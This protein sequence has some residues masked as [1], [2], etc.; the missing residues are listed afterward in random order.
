MRTKKIINEPIYIFISFLV[1]ILVVAASLFLI[2]EKNVLM[3]C[4]F[5][6]FL[7]LIVVSY[8][9]AMNCFS[10]VITYD[11]NYIARKGLFFGMRLKIHKDEIIE[12][13]VLRIGRTEYYEL[14]DGKHDSLALMSKKGSIKI[15]CTDR[16]K[17]FIKSFWSEKIV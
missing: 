16:G 7:V 13:R 1:L 6:P 14:Y 2:K 10:C 15:S 9:I 8:F 11:G 5:L 17:E 4:I 3:L 12:V